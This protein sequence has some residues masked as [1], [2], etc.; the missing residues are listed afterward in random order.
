MAEDAV[1]AGD[2]FHPAFTSVD[3][4][5]RDRGFGHFFHFFGGR[6]EQHGEFR[7]ESLN[8][9]PVLR[10]HPGIGHEHLKNIGDNFLQRHQ[11]F[12]RDGAG[13]LKTFGLVSQFADAIQNP[14]SQ[15]T[16]AFGAKVIVSGGFFGR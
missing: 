3:N 2:Q 4:S 9:F 1:V 11:T 7:T 14:N 15:R 10:F 8:Q 12:V 13:G 16:A 6:S 5:P